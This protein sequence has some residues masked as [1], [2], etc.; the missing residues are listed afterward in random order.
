MAALLYMCGCWTAGGDGRSRG[1]ELMARARAK[2]KLAWK[3]EGD[4]GY[5]SVVFREDYSSGVLLLFGGCF[6]GLQYKVITPDVASFRSLSRNS[7]GPSIHVRNYE[8][9]YCTAFFEFEI[10]LAEFLDI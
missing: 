5:V 2:A 10:K 1:F 6:V 4:D 8:A 9:A 3:R 7:K